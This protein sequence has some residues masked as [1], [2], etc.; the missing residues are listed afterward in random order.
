MSATSSA[1]SMSMRV[2]RGAAKSGDATIELTAPTDRLSRERKRFSSKG[3]DLEGARK[4]L[5]WKVLERR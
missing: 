1:G 5:T 2:A 3:A 4:A